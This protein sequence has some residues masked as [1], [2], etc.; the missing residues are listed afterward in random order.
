M[1]LDFGQHNLDENLHQRVPRNYFLSR[2]NRTNYIRW[3]AENLEIDIPSVNTA[4]W[5]NIT[6]VEF[7]QPITGERAFAKSI[8]NHF[9]KYCDVTRNYL[10]VVMDSFPDEN[11]MPW[12]IGECTGNSKWTNVSI[13]VDGITLPDQ[14]SDLCSDDMEVR[15]ITGREIC[16]NFIQCFSL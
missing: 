5:Y 13:W 15:H 8:L 12:R 4:P 2:E 11:W 16:R 3:L 10:A 1:V 9:T 14:N 6:N 7:T